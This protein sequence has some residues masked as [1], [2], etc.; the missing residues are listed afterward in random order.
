MTDLLN[1]TNLFFHV[2]IA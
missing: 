1:L 2:D